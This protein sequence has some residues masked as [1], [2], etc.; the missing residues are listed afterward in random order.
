MFKTIEEIREAN[1]RAGLF[2]F[3]PD[4][5]RFFRS[6]VGRE[7]YG[8]RFFVT[9]EQFDDSSPRLYSVRRAND[10][11][12]ID[13]ASEFQGYTSGAEARLAAHELARLEEVPS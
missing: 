13:T 8:G 3:S 7:V 11:G 4:T 6:R 2:F 10:D 1:R 5:M 9:S 12:S